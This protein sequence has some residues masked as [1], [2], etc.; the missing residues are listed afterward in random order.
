MKCIFCQSSDEVTS[1]NIKY[2]D[3]LVEVHICEKHAEESTVKDI[4]EA[5]AS[6]QDRIKEL[7][8]ELESHGYEVFKKGA[9]RKGGGQVQVAQ[10]AQPDPQADAALSKWGGGQN[11]QQRPVAPQVHTEDTEAAAVAGIEAPHALPQLQREVTRP[12]GEQGQGIQIQDPT[13]TTNIKI[14]QGVTN[15]QLEDRVKVHAHDPAKLL[16]KSNSDCVACKGSGIAFNGATC[17][18]CKGSGIIMR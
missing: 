15:K 17:P 13:G 7:I 18:R 14:V 5:Y 9:P 6:A 10:P 8:E 2:E 11:Q 12:D 1:M 4:R 3:A 16:H